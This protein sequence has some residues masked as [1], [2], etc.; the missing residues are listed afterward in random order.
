M[1][2]FEILSETLS[3]PCWKMQLNVPKF[4][5]FPVAFLNQRQLNFSFHLLSMCETE[6]SNYLERSI[7]NNYVLQLFN[8]N[9]IVKQTAMHVWR[10]RFLHDTCRRWVSFIGWEHVYID[11]YLKI[12]TN[13]IYWKVCLINDKRHGLIYKWNYRTI[14]EATMNIKLFYL[15]KYYGLQEA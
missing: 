5:R 4:L 11:A 12:C 15:D 3:Y 9:N 2:L 7:E 6:N 14:W 10:L 13:P 1:N 8:I